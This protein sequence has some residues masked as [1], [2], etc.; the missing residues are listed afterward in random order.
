MSGKHKQLWLIT[1]F[2]RPRHGHFV[3]FLRHREQIFFAWKLDALKK[4]KHGEEADFFSPF[5]SFICFIFIFRGSNKEEDFFQP[6]QVPFCWLIGQL[7]RVL[8]RFV[9]RVWL[10][11]LSLSL[12]CFQRFMGMLKK[13]RQEKKSG[14][15]ANAAHSQSRDLGL[16]LHLRRHWKLFFF[17]FT[18]I[19]S[20]NSRMTN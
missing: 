7:Y 11:S 20:S 1:N 6:W 12:Y 18:P 17:F 2:P 15:Y 8:S 4:K 9:P 14:N 19:S 10:Q 3:F 16:F 13:R 5:L